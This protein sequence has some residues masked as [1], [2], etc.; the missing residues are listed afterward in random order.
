[1]LNTTEEEITEYKN[2]VRFLTHDI[3]MY[4]KTRHS[5]YPSL[6]SLLPQKMK[7]THAQ[8]LDRFSINF[9]VLN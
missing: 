8:K 1:M 6:S 2:F 7:L 5:N 3:A 9:S 4:T